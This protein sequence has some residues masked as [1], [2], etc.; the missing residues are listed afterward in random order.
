LDCTER[1]PKIVTDLLFSLYYN[2]WIVTL[3][4]VFLFIGKDEEV[5]DPGELPETT[6]E[7]PKEI[8][9]P[10][11]GPKDQPEMQEPSHEDQ[12]CMDRG[13]GIQ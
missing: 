7:Q 5:K 13:M 10:E 1:G 8:V 6:E 12:V 3:S 9:S 2:S 11:G 4:L